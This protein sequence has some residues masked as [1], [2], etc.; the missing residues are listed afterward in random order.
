MLTVRAAEVLGL[1]EVVVYDRLVDSRILKMVSK[2]AELVDVGKRPGDP[3]SQEGINDSLVALARAGRQ[4]VRLKGGDPFVFGRGGE[5]IQALRAAGLEFEVVPGVSSAIAVPASAG[6]P[7]TYRGLATSFT[8]VSG[9]AD[10][11]A[12]SD[13]SGHS[14]DWGALARLGGTIVVLM[15]VAHRSSIAQALIEEGRSPGTPVAV[16]EW[17]ATPRQ[18]VQRATL[19]DL[20]ALDIEAPAVLVIGQV[21]GLDL[22]PEPL[23]GSSSRPLA[24]WRVVVTRT[25]LQA[26]K[27]ASRLSALGAEVIDLAVQELSEPEDKRAALCAAASRIASYS[28]VVFT[29]ANAVDSLMACVRDARSLFGPK[30][31]AVGPATVA[32]LSRAGIVADLVAPDAT[33]SSLVEAFPAAQISEPVGCGAAERA[34]D[35]DGSPLVLFPRSALAGETISVGIKAKGWV[36]EEVE[37]YTMVPVTPEIKLLRRAVDADAICFASPSA[38]ASY[39]CALQAHGLE[40]TAPRVVAC[41]GPTTAEAAAQAGFKVCAVPKVRTAEAMAD[42]LADWRAANDDQAS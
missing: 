25:P 13:S 4:V 7:V 34:S 41:I 22:S 37:A 3:L 12:P 39:C 38:V 17:G 26:A 32:A 36:V 21:A 31:A 42:S 16:V 40:L 1:A 18:R 27:L 23:M 24:G 6:V 35:T 8:V 14:I 20:G 10:P 9:H 19:A 11:L 15:G 5:E 29:S 30:V 33:A 28:W 2:D